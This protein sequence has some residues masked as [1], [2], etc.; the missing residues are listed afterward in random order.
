MCT[1]VSTQSLTSWNKG[2]WGCDPGAALG[3]DRCPSPWQF[4]AR[5]LAF[6]QASVL[7][8]SDF[9]FSSQWKKTAS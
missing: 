9:P 8:V 3:S 4:P 6:S 7:E 5:M 1:E 2:V